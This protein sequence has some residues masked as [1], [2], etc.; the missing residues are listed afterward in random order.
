MDE[1]GNERKECN[2]EDF[3]IRIEEFSKRQIQSLCGLSLPPYPSG[4]RRRT[5]ASWS[6]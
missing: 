3:R 4:E 2:K 5:G 6:H 1:R